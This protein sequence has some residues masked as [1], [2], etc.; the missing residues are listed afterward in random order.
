MN[1]LLCGMLSANWVVGLLQ[2]VKTCDG[3]VNGFDH[4]FFNGFKLVAID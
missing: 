2:V 4:T 3:P 1:L